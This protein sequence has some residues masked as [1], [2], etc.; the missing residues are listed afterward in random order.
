[1][2]DEPFDQTRNYRYDSVMRLVQSVQGDSVIDYVLDGLGNRKS[3]AGQGVPSV[4]GVPNRNGLGN[5]AMLSDDAAANQYTFT[6]MAGQAHDA[7]GNL[8]RLTPNA[9]DGDADGD[10]DLDDYDDFAGCF[11]GINT[12]GSS[13][14][15]GCPTF[16]FDADDDVD[17]EDFAVFQFA[18][19]ENPPEGGR[20]AKIAYDYRNRMVRYEDLATV[21]GEES[22]LRMARRALRLLS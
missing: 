2:I 20:W 18:F 13:L 22:L 11:T 15:S 14:P 6:P 8:I 1:M 3:V 19:G 9:A 16:D 4:P 12:T 7:N 21:S 5:Y 10:V 17:L